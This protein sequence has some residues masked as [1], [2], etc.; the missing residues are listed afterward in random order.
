MSWKLNGT[1]RNGQS[2]SADAN[3]HDEAVMTAA[4]LATSTGNPVTVTG[5]LGDKREVLGW[6]HGK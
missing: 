5:P 4:D 6:K 3:G 2:V 1:S